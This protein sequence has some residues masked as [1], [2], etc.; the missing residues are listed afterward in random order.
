[1]SN[2]LTRARRDDAALRLMTKAPNVHGVGTKIGHPTLE[3][4]LEA[5]RQET[6]RDLRQRLRDAR[7]EWTWTSEVRDA[8]DTSELDGREDIELELIRM[9]TDLLH[10]IDEALLRIHHG[11]YGHCVE[12]RQRIS[13][14]RL[15]ALPFAPRCRKCEEARERA[16]QSTRPAAAQERTPAA[17]VEMRG[18]RP[19]LEQYESG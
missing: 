13:E 11:T 15:R 14:R 10:R 5:R 19:R 7:E 6:L 17:V 8:A 16:A 1:M 4:I 18:W 9:K 2:W 12:C 3:E